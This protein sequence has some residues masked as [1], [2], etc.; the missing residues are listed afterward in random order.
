M[1]HTLFI[2]TFVNVLRVC[3]PSPLARLQSVYKCLGNGHH[4]GISG[5]FTLFSILRFAK[6]HSLDPATLE[7]EVF[8]SQCRYGQSRQLRIILVSILVDMLFCFL[9]VLSR[10]FSQIPNLVLL[11]PNC[12]WEFDHELLKVVVGEEGIEPPTLAL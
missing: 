2:H 3:Q 7:Q 6:L 12:H 1:H 5:S 11:C 10:S 9:L 4:S 8:S